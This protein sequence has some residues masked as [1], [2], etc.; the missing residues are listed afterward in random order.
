MPIDTSLIVPIG[1]NLK[2]PE[3]QDP[4]GALFSGVASG[5][6][7]GEQ[8]SERRTANSEF[9]QDFTGA[10]GRTP[11]KEESNRNLD[12]SGIPRG[13]FMT[14]MTQGVLGATAVQRAT[15][16]PLFGEKQASAREDVRGKRFTNNLNDQLARG[17][18]SLISEFSAIEGDDKQTATEKRLKFFQDNAGAALTPAGGQL[19]SH[20]FQITGELHK[21][22]SGTTAAMLKI[23]ASKD[24]VELATK[25]GGIVGDPGSFVLARKRRAVEE[26]LGPQAVRMGVQLTHVGNWFNE[27]GNLDITKAIPEMAQM[28]SRQAFDPFAERKLALRERAYNQ[29][30]VRTALSELGL[31]LRATK[32]GYLIENMPVTDSAPTTP[33]TPGGPANTAAP[34]PSLVPI[35]RPLT[36]QNVTR[37]QETFS[38]S[39]TG[40]KQI[41]RLQPLINSDTVGPLASF[42]DIVVDR[43]LANIF[44]ELVG[45][46][47]VKVNV[48]L[49][50]L[51][52]SVAKSLRS[53][54]NIAEPE[55]VS[56][57][58]QIPHPN[59]FFTSP[60][61]SFEQL[62]TIQ[63][64]ITDRAIRAAR[65]LKQTLPDE[66]IKNLPDEWILDLHRDNTLTDDEVRR[67]HRLNTSE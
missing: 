8:W 61:R 15:A 9:K 25:Y 54:S 67:W 3:G 21:I 52:S 2:I 32:E 57:L 50:S 55:R 37:N 18:G 39:A 29:A 42:Q 33:T 22:E 23:A 49:S 41:Q 13:N 20:L 19:F 65:N 16:D 40:L 31:Q 43:G 58:E 4:F 47:R 30:D 28:P 12:R 44:P 59:E 64:G 38:Q 56:L 45:K 60:A 7:A 27:N 26:E 48:L 34:R 46:D 62:K 17:A 11:T 51:S 1:N 36:T 5:M 6:K 10:Y 24:I 66:F 63:L 53:D 35:E 14:D